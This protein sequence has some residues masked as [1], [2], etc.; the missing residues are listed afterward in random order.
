MQNTSIIMTSNIFE[1]KKIVSDIEE[2]MVY[3]EKKNIIKN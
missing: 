2:V 3:I 1:K